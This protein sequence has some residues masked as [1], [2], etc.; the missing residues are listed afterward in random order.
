MKKRIILA[1][2]VVAIL[3]TSS[4]SAGLVA[5]YT[6]DDPANLSAN[7]GS[8]TLVWNDN[9]GVTATQGMFGGAGAFLAG[10]S[11][12]WMNEFSPAVANLSNFSVSM[13]VRGVGSAWDDYLSIGIGANVFVLERDD[14]GNCGLYSIGNPGGMNASDFAGST[15]INDGTW[16]HLGMVSDGSTI[17]LYIDGVSAGSTP[18]TGNG[19]ITSFQ[20]ASRFADGARAITADIDDVAVYNTALTAGQMRWLA[21]NAAVGNPPGDSLAPPK[22]NL[23]A[24]NQPMLK[25]PVD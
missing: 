23:N 24:H 8:A 5:H 13:H 18:Y 3:A 2:S 19:T 17:E 14:S 20:I 4:A 1:A 15:V 22:K 6:F 25:T 10:T 9:T 21:S 12:Y 7:T 11:Q 16:H